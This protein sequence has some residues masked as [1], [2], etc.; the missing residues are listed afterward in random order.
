MSFTACRACAPP[1]SP[2]LSPILPPFT[3][4]APADAVT[5]PLPK[6]AA[7][8][9]PAKL[10]VSRDAALRDEAAVGAAGSRI[11]AAAM[12]SGLIKT[13]ANFTA[14]MAERRFD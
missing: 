9:D 3:D 1:F 4:P 14:A 2:S 6:A 13:S 12:A 11:E 5:K 7:G 10:P 8:E